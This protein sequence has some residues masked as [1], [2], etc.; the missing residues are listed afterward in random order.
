MSTAFP[1]KFL[2]DC[3][4]VILPPE[5]KVK[6][7]EGSIVVNDGQGV[8]ILPPEFKVKVSRAIFRS[9]DKLVV[10]FADQGWLYTVYLDRAE[11]DNFRA[12]WSAQSGGQK[13][14]GHATCRMYSSTSDILLLG[15]WT[16]NGYDSTWWLRLDQVE[17][18]PDERSH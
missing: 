15:T 18:F 14:T 9:P 3:W 13:D 6:V 17:H 2:G 5:F 8:V 1:K 4:R 10:E 16:E 11:G 7:S 12:T